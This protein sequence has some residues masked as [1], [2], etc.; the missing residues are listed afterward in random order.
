[1]DNDLREIW[2]HML[3][4]GMGALAHAIQNSAFNTI[5]NPRKHELSVLHAA[6][7]AEI[8]LKA[9]IAQEHPL[10]I[11][12]QV[13]GPG[14][15]H[16][17]SLDDLLQRGRSVQYADLP[18]RLWAAT[19]LRLRNTKL[20]DSFGKLRNMIQHFA[21]PKRKDLDRETL[22]FIFGVIDPF[23][24]TCWGLHAIDY[25]EDTTLEYVI[26]GLFHHRIPFLVSPRAASEWPDRYGGIDGA[27]RP[28]REV[29][30]RRLRQARAGEEQS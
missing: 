19:G 17:L 20:Y 15:N 14:Q 16:L 9:R 11:F 12:E 2:R 18:D 13:P 25:N 6:H 10:L 26:L 30:R 3:G 27:P 22:N 24:Y 29:M 4:L 23:I 7:A 28:Y 1:M 5:D 8:I 21:A